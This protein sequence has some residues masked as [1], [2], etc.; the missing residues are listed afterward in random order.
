MA[1]NFRSIPFIELTDNETGEKRTIDAGLVKQI[2]LSKGGFV[3]VYWRLESFIVRESYET[4]LEL[5]IRAGLQI[6]RKD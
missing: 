2:T 1:E 5:C 6:I 3:T 4:V